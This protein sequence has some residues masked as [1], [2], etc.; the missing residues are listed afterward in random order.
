MIQVRNHDMWGH[1]AEVPVAT[2]NVG[3]QPEQLVLRASNAELTKW[4]MDDAG[5][6]RRAAQEVDKAERF[7]HPTGFS[8]KHEVPTPIDC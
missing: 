8:L 7:R 6:D 1:W 3:S 4:G 2:T 5:N